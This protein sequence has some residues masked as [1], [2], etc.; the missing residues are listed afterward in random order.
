VTDSLQ[1]SAAPRQRMIAAPL[2]LYA[3]EASWILLPL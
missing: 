1:N 3:A 2:H